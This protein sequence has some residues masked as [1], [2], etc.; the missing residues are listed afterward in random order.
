MD[1][2]PSNEELKAQINHLEGL[3]Q[4]MGTPVM[5]F[6]E[7]GI[8]LMINNSALL[9]LKGTAA[10]YLGRSIESFMPSDSKKFLF[11]IKDVCKNGKIATY[12]TEFILDT[13]SLWFLT[14]YIPVFDQNRK[15]YAVQTVSIDITDRKKAENALREN[16]EIFNR[17]MEH[18]PIYVFFKDENI[19]SVHLSRN[20]EQLLG[21]P[22]NEILGK[23]M[24]EIFPSDLAKSMIADDK[25]VLE[26]GKMI[27]VV[28]E[29][30]GRFYET[31]KF[32]IM[33]D[34][35]PKCLAGYTMD[36]TEKKRTKEKLEGNVL[37]LKTLMDTIPSPIFYTDKDLRYLGGNRAWAEGVVGM[38]IED[39]IGRTIYE[40]C[41]KMPKEIAEI[42]KLKDLELINAG[43]TQIFESRIMCNDE[44][45]R[46]F[47]I[48]K[49]T[50]LDSEGNIAGIVGVMLDITEQKR[51]V[52]EKTILQKRL[53][54]AQKMESIGTLAG[55]IAHDFNNILLPIMAF[56]ELAA[57]KLSTESPIRSDLNQIHKAA[58]RARGL[59]HQ[60]LTFARQKETERIPIKIS[61]ILKETVKLLRSSIPATIDVSYDI[62]AE[63]DMVLADPTKINQIIMNLSTNAAH[64][65]EDTGGFLKIILTNENIDSESTKTF[66]ELEHGRYVRLTVKDT[67]HGILPH[68][69]EKIFE[70]YFTTKEPG[71]GTGMGLSIVHGIVKNY[72]GEITV[73]SEVNKGTSFHVY[74]PV[75]Q[76]DTHVKE[77]VKDVG[78]LQMGIEHILAVDDMKVSLDTLQSMLEWLGYKVTGRTSS[79]EALEAFKNHPEGFDLVIT[80]QTMPNMTGKTLIEEMMVIRPD[81]PYILCTGFS[82]QIDEKKAKEIGI[83][84][85]I[86]K[87]I[88]IDQLA[89]IIR[90]VL[91]KNESS[92]NSF[93]KHI[94]VTINSQ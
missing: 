80:D 28:E 29:F 9:Y 51:A 7:A 77:K 92:L 14:R 3:I 4:N 69:L 37:F 88:V 44:K 31:I 59:V 83:S 79:I 48:Y 26:E 76:P 13:G 87:P 2:N 1:T 86:M 82:E 52:E 53:Q 58:G 11:R 62:D 10:E 94:D 38:N 65:M 78:P 30:N 41:K 43:G 17:F 42:H 33:F 61:T 49:S 45:G 35:K 18:N 75:I 47:I 6:D 27:T 63:E 90:D 50:Y 60:I 54:Q 46:D 66:S 81:I 24:D 39:V 89:R 23:T 70:P 84:A 34:G 22:I 72:G 91:D 5:L 74:L 20:Y 25:H 85:F 19:R 73:Q 21:M 8:L 55:G 64:A 32:P 16:Q 15:V 40:V 68:L 71:K 93:N 12:E 56:S 57:M 67:G 36:V